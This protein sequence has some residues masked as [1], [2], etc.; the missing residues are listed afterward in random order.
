MDTKDF[1]NEKKNFL[2]GEELLKYAYINFSTESYKK[3][4]SIF[5]AGVAQGVADSEDKT[6]R[7][8]D[9]LDEQDISLLNIRHD[10]DLIISDSTLS[11][12]KLIQKL[13]ELWEEYYGHS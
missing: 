9:L 7:L 10:L 11:K 12:D 3:I 8:D 13:K 6:D 2:S 4:Q 1:F 5:D